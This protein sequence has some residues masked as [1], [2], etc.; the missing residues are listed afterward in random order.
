M[1]ICFVLGLLD[2]HCRLYSLA[3]RCNSTLKDPLSL[4]YFHTGGSSTYELSFLSIICFVCTCQIGQSCN[5][6]VLCQPVLPIPTYKS[7]SSVMTQ[8]P[9]L[10]SLPPS[11]FRFGG[12]QN[13]RLNQERLKSKESSLLVMSTKHIIFAHGAVDSRRE[14]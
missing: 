10:T 13:E 14:D 5:T 8:K 4:R 7:G 3:W 12:E 6:G 11:L 9:V 2:L 1:L